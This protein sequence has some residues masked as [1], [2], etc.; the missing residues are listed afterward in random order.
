[1]ETQVFISKQA[2][3]RAKK[4]RFIKQNQRWYDHQI[5]M[6]KST[7][8]ARPL[9]KIGDFNV[10]P[11]GHEKRRIAWHFEIKGE[12]ILISIVDLLYHITEDKY[13]NN[14]NIK[15]VTKQITLRNYGPYIPFIGL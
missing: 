5:R 4:D 3:E 15:A 11:R 2:M 7:P 1:M 6:I 10:T 12:V 9:E 8:L 14:W 13:V